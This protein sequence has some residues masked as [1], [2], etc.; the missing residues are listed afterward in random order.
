MEEAERHGEL[1]AHLGAHRAW[2]RKADV[3]GMRWCTATEDT[4][5]RG[6]ELQMVGVPEP[7]RRGERQFRRAGFACWSLDGCFG[8]LGQPFEP[9]FEDPLQHIGVV[10]AVCGLEIGPGGSEM[11]NRWRI[12]RPDPL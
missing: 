7:F 9:L 10:R 8:R 12:A 5:L 6:N 3:V 11:S 1:V 2:L 4:G